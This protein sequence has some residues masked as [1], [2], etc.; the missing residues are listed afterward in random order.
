MVETTTRRRGTISVGSAPESQTY[1]VIS[2]IFRDT[3]SGARVCRYAGRTPT[4]M[5]GRGPSAKWCG[6]IGKQ[7]DVGFDSAPWQSSSSIK[8]RSRWLCINKKGT[9]WGCRCRQRRLLTNIRLRTVAAIPA[10]AIGSHGNTYRSTWHRVY[11]QD[12]GYRYALRQDP[13][14]PARGRVPNTQFQLNGVHG[15]LAK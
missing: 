12:L 3:V 10:L 1:V 14:Q 4:Y 6:L 2:K 15:Y 13:R 11:A 7:V 9:A 8:R 5:R